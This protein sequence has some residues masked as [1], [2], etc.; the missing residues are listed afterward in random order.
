[1]IADTGELEI[2]DASEI[3]AGRLNA[4]KV[5]IPENGEN[6]KFTI[7]DGTVKYE[8]KKTTFFK[9]SR[10][11]LNNQTHVRMKVKSET[12]FGRSLEITFGVTTL[13]QELSSMCS[14]KSCSQ[15]HSNTL[16]LSGGRR[17]H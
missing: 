15:Y 4:S 1:M 13:N 16:T 5:L 2:L 6:L 10:T 3:C 9:E 17:R 11:G 8:A 7:A 12:I 14:R